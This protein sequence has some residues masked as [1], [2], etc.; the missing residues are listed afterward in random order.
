MRAGAASGELRRMLP[1]LVGYLAGAAVPLGTNDLDDT[2]DALRPH[3]EA[4]GRQ[5]SIPF[6]E[7]VA[8]K[9]RRA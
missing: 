7:R 1:Q 4:Y 6:N 8:E 9:R 5:R 3:I 2:F